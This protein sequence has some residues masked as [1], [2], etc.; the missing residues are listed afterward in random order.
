MQQFRKIR[1]K[2]RQQWIIFPLVIVV[3]ALALIGSFAWPEKVKQKDALRRIYD[4]GYLIALTNTNSLNY[5]IYNGQP[6]GYQLELLQSFADYLDVPLRIIAVNDLEK[7]YYYLDLNVA[8]I[9]AFNLPVSGEGKK[10]VRFSQ[11]LGETRQVL[12]QRKSS[13]GKTKK[14][15]GYIHEFKNFS[16]D[17]ITIIHNPFLSPFLKTVMRKSGH[18]VVFIEEKDKTQEELIRLVSLGKINYTICD[19]NLAMVVKRY[20]QNIDA[21]FLVSSFTPYAWGV[22]NSSDSLLRKINAWLTD[23]KASGSLKYITLSYYNNPRTTGY[24][25][26]NNFTVKA[27]RLSPFDAQLQA[28][29]KTISWDWR[30][31]ASLIYEESNFITGLKSSHNA[32]GLMQLMPE[33]ARKFGMDSASSPSQQ[34]IA[35]VRFLNWLDQQWLSE[36]IDRK[37]RI[38]FIL[39][40]YNVGMGR[41]MAAREK[42]ASN[43]RDPNKWNNNVDYYLTRHNRTD[44]ESPPDSVLDNSPFG[45]TGGFVSNILERYHH[46]KNNLPK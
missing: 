25:N 36:I 38:N 10:L 42:A 9:F 33:T 8:D 21:N 15:H 46:Y 16:G 14:P 43:G 19:E 2:K 7:L 32:T 22:R 3:I 27:A 41:V 35:G 6:M 40:S 24:F 4:R 29:S 26:S 11:A 28:L 34:L 1:L 31:L 18:K 12:I 37:E 39:A 17:T 20:Y 5:F 30:L 44:D 45:T 13:P 23:I